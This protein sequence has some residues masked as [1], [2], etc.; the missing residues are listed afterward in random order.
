M[1]Q[2]SCPDCGTL[3]GHS[4]KSDCDI[5]RCSSCRSQRIT[6]ECSDHEPIWSV[7]T[8]YFPTPKNISLSQ[9]LASHGS[10]FFA[11]RHCYSNCFNAV[12]MVPE[13]GCSTYVEGFAF[14][15]LLCVEHAWLEINGEIV[16]PTLLSQRM[17]YFPGL[18]FEGCKQLSDAL[19]IKKENVSADL[20]IF[21]RFGFGGH[22]SKSFHS[23]RQAADRL[24]TLHSKLRRASPS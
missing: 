5:E 12:T 20:P 24:W 15:G 16:D 10:E 8:G 6:C 22:E 2:E 23:A 3:A 11:K 21:Y 1:F 13:Y 19:K 9:K 4:H 18:R 14:N 7:W 17:V